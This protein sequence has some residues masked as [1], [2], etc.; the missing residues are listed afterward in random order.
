MP[1]KPKKCCGKKVMFTP[2]NIVTKWA[3]KRLLFID[4]PNIKGNQ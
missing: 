3:F 4:R 2:I 1:F